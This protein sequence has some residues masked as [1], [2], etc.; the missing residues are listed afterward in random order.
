MARDY[1]RVIT[2]FWN[3][4]KIRKCSDRG[5]L[6]A[7]YLM[8]G[9]HSNSIGAYLLPDAYVSDDLGWTP[10]AVSKAFAELFAIG[11]AQ[12]FSDGRHVVVCDF[13]DWNPIE[14]PNVGKGALKQV[15]QLPDD[16]AI[17]HIFNGLQQYAQHF[18][19]GL[20]SVRKRFRNMEPNRTEPEMEPEPRKIAPQA[21]APRSKPEMVIEPEVIED[22]EPP[23]SCD[24]TPERAALDAY[25]ALAAEQD[26]SHAQ[27]L[28][29]TRRVQIRAR[30]RECGGL[31]GW[32]TA[33]AKAR[34]SPFLRGET[35]RGPGHE[36]WKPD[37]DFFLQEKTFTR[38]M[39]GKYDGRTG[40]GKP[41]ELAEL[42]EAH[43]LSG[44][45]H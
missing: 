18:P 11:F 2:T 33:M 13:L 31:D 20:E 44:G 29:S 7:T 42:Y 40:S 35:G 16:L 25:N 39:E 28:T 34:A 9:P 22:E 43:R 26:W 41:S 21:D 4:P 3:H 45:A 32:G 19:N 24:R 30:L 14:N 17:E 5:K 15:D 10:E 27:R 1:G 23:A 37:I 8:T 12:R 38:L 6:L 36:S